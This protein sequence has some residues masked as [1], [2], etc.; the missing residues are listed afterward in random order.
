MPAPETFTT[1]RWSRGAIDRADEAFLAAML[2]RTRT[3]TRR[4]VA[5]EMPSRGRETLD[6]MTG[7]LGTTGL[8]GLD[9][10]RSGHARAGRLGRAPRARTSA[11]PAGSSSLYA[12]A[13]TRWREGLATRSGPRGRGRSARGLLGFDELVCVTMVENIASRADHGGTRLR[14]RRARS[15]TPGCPHVLHATLGS[16]RREGPNVGEYAASA[17]AIDGIGDARGDR[18]QPVQRA[19]HRRA[20]RRRAPRA[21]RTRASPTRTSRS[22]GSPAHSS[23][24]SSRSTWPELGMVRQRRVPRRGDPGR[25]AALRLRRRVKR[26]GG[27]RRPRWRPASRSC[28]AC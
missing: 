12:I 1:E 27:C 3:V 20:A 17:D 23:S 9:P 15:S 6:R 8:R 26:H 18:R 10:A 19:H 16:N 4:S 7:A 21:S 25:H 11:A 5:R 24:R 14:R 13:S 22:R 28:S 2:R